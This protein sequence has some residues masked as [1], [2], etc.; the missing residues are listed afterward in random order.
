MRS[1]TVNLHELTA[2]PESILTLFNMQQL[3][4]QG[5]ASEVLTPAEDMLK[6][7]FVPDF[8]LGKIG[9]E[10]QRFPGFQTSL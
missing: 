5:I 9:E 3:G 2:L 7:F 8:I 4:I 10:Y 1:V 6:C